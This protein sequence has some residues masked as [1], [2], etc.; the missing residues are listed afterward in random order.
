MVSVAPF[1]CSTGVWPVM[2]VQS[3]PDRVSYYLGH[4]PAPTSD[5]QQDITH[6]TFIISLPGGFTDKAF[7]TKRWRICSVGLE[8]G[9][10]Y[11]IC[12][13][14]LNYMNL[15]CDDLTVQW[16]DCLCCV[17]LQSLHEREQI[18]P[19]RQRVITLL[20]IFHNQEAEQSSHRLLNSYKDSDD[21]THIL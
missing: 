11:D 16:R 4:L 3:E 12:S 21:R 14:S 9:L 15:M 20:C 17:Q 5:S 18:F 10:L 2:R 19:W 6:R 13:P 8:N 1:Q 7:N